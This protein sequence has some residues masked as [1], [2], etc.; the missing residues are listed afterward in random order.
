LIYER[1]LLGLGRVS[2]G[3]LMLTAT[4]VRFDALGETVDVGVEHR[5]DEQCQQR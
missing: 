1:W 3:F 5:H 4:P 2:A